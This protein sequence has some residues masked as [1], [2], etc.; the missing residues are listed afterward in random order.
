MKIVNLLKTASIKTVTYL[1]LCGFLLAYAEAANAL[2][3]IPMS[4]ALATSPGQVP[5]PATA[6]TQ[7]TSEVR[8]RLADSALVA[9]GIV[10]SISEDYASMNWSTAH[11]AVIRPTQTFKGEPATK[12]SVLVPIGIKLKDEVVIFANLETQKDAQIRADWNKAI[13]KPNLAW[14]QDTSPL[15]VASVPCITRTYSTKNYQN[16]SV[17]LKQI[18]SSTA[19]SELLINVGIYSAGSSQQAGHDKKTEFSHKKIKFIKDKTES[20]LTFE[21]QPLIKQTEG[22]FATSMSNISEGKYVIFPPKI[23]GMSALCSL[24]LIKFD[25]ATV[26]FKPHARH[27]LSI[28]YRPSA[29]IHVAQLPRTIEST[30]IEYEFISLDTKSNEFSK[31]SFISGVLWDKLFLLPG[32]YNIFAVIASS[33]PSQQRRFQISQD[34]KKV[35]NFS[36]GVNEITVNTNEFTQ[37]IETI[38]TWQLPVGVTKSVTTSFQLLSSIRNSDRIYQQAETSCNSDGCKIFALQGQS[39]E[40]AASIYGTEFSANKI[41]R[42]GDQAAVNLTFAPVTK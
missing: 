42:I 17:A 11:L 10:E 19:T 37:P 16:I 27:K 6:L 1:G 33:I 38:V 30:P 9:Q 29:Q 41:I 4:P 31:I 13:K 7:A 15:W 12:L 18:F 32:K 20:K 26:E 40:I 21:S 35:F 23:H 24:D 2:S 14:A 22:F 25:C 39:I 5:I 34:G 36:A 28:N 3:C 8:S